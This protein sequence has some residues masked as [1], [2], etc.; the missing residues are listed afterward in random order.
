MNKEIKT[1]VYTNLNNGELV[2][3]DFDTKEQID[4]YFNPDYM[5]PLCIVDKLVYPSGCYT[6]LNES[7]TM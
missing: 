6:V 5:Y 4:N 1:F 3:K 2:K 7:Y